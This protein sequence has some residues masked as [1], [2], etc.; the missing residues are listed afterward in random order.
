LDAAVLLNGRLLYRVH[1][2][3]QLS[4]LRSVLFIA[5][6]HKERGPDDDHTNGGCHSILGRLAV[7]LSG[8]SSS[9]S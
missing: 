7:L 5:L 6:D 1:L 3:F 9:G 8:S 2:T 4:Q